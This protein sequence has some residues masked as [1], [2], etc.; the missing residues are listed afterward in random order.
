MYDNISRL[1][2][3]INILKSALIDGDAYQKCINCSSIQRFEYSLSHGIH[4]YTDKKAR[5]IWKERNSISLHYDDK[6]ME[7]NKKDE[8]YIRHETLSP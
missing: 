7:K 1:S 8:K 5:K 6:V 4:F 2:T 3:L